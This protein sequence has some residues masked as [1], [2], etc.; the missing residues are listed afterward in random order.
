[1]L[2]KF[3][4]HVESRIRDHSILGQPVDFTHFEGNQEFQNCFQSEFIKQIFYNYNDNNN[5]FS[6]KDQTQ[7]QVSEYMLEIND[8]VINQIY[9]E[10]IAYPKK[11]S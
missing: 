4:S 10:L 1:M 6:F 3:Y 5:D 8:Y 9:K 7:T 2:H 11:M